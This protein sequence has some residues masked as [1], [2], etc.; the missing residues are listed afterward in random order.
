ML[1]RTKRIP[2]KQNVY[3]NSYFSDL[4]DPRKTSGHFYYPLDEILFLTISA[5]I[6]GLDTWPAIHSFGEI[7]QEWLR[8]FFPYAEGI[9]SQ[10]VLRGVFARLDP[11][12]FGKCFV[13][14]IN[15]V[16]VLTKGEV[17]AIDGKAI[18]GSASSD[19]KNSAIH[20]VSAYATENRLCLGQE[21][22]DKKENE[23]IAIPKLLE[24]LAINGCIVT[25]DAIGCQKKI[26]RA[27]LDRGADYIL[28]VKDNQKELSDQI[29]KIFR[30]KRSNKKDETIDAGHGRI[31]TR[32]CEALDDLTFMDEKELWPG[33]KSIV[34]VQSFRHIKKTG[35]TSKEIRYYITSLNPEPSMLNHAIRAHWRIENNLH[36][37]LDVTFNEDSARRKKDNSP[38]N[39]N[40]INK[41][42]LALIEKDKNYK[43]SK[44]LKRVKAAL[45][46]TYREY[47]IFGQDQ[48]DLCDYD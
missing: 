34:R 20:V 23:I 44:N 36:W 19:K 39:F 37:T 32:I 38:A 29:E 17:V 31:E 43:A 18:R 46:D 40:I 24:L 41:I 35:E 5:V 45:D 22:V 11:V 6:S 16:S 42:S 4:K 25:I 28:M 7:K 12:G 1:D 48:L 33:L 2:N 9:P 13:K 3:F 10:S 26:A 8:K 21:T 14:W 27:I 15:S 47:L 30:L